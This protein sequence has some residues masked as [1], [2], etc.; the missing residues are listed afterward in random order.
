MTAS[1]ISWRARATAGN[2]LALLTLIQG[3][4]AEP[5]VPACMA[6]A[7]TP[8][9]VRIGEDAPRPA[10]LRGGTSPALQ[11]ID[12]ATSQPLWSASAASP[13]SQQFA[14]MGAQFAG[15]LLPIDLDGDGTHDRIYAGDLAGRLWR[16]DLHHGLPAQL[17]ATGGIFGDFSS[18]ARGFVAPPD[19]SLS[20]TNPPGP[21][22]WFNIALGTVRVGTGSV[23]NRFYVL[24]D[25]F[26][27]ESWTQARYNRWQP[28]REGDLAR[29]PR[30][31]AV[32]TDAAPNGYFIEIG[33]AE[34]LSPSITV[35]GRA[36]LAL[37]DPDRAA[38][39]ACGIAVVVSSI[40]LATGAE[41]GSAANGAPA[42]RIALQARAGEAFTLR[43]EESLAACTLGE[44][45]V[46]SCDVDLSVHRTWW[47]REDAD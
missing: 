27:F 33:G 21:G 42:A 6:A 4:C 22:A 41:A 47:R 40:D 36:T 1:T 38:G 46:P 34:I 39:E 24:R 23:D 26:A 19:V 30:L 28:L 2:A 15:S 11:V 13:A 14:A 18:G 10:L 44:T 12:A 3:H 37:T 7:P 31:G 32:L 9:M 20:G 45:R 29:L 16:F 17:W 43:R 8:I 25:R 5:S 35:S